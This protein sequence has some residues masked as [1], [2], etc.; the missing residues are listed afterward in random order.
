MLTLTIH[1]TK[2]TYLSACHHLRE[3]GGEKREGVKCC[4][5][6]QKACIFS[7]HMLS[8][9]IFAMIVASRLIYK[10]FGKRLDHLDLKYIYFLA[11]DALSANM[12]IQQLSS[13]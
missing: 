1:F 7:V 3:R 10:C 9:I 2:L 6:K 11:L 13:K 4:F 8:M 5:S 12:K